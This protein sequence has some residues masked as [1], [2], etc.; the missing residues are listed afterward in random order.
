M[1]LVVGLGNP[2]SRY[3]R[4]RHNLGFMV[5]D[6]LA[7]RWGVT[8]AGRRHDAETGLATFAGVRTVLAKPLTFMNA[9]GEA[10]AKLRRAHRLD[11]ASIIA[12]YDELDLPLG[13]V[14]VRAAGSAGGHRGV[15]SL[16]AALG[17]GFPRVRIGIG[18]P[19]GGADPVEYV[20]EP[21]ARAEEPLVESV[22]ERAADGIE[23][24]LR[25]GIERTMNTFNRAA[26]NG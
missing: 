3:R 16:V 12:V 25:D 8:L 26:A 1:K 22:I 15:A 13:R 23:S 10:V 24:W 5:V 6:C 20:L 9:S 14:R 11:P 4:T 2:G 19:L 7:E 18:R 21:F 17:T